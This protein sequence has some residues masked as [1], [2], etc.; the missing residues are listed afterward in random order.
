MIRWWEHSQKGVT[1]GRTDRR[2]D[3]RTENTIHRAAWSQL[4][5]SLYPGYPVSPGHL[6]PSHWPSKT[7]RS[8]ILM[9]KGFLPLIAVWINDKKNRS[10][11]NVPNKIKHIKGYLQEST[12][13]L[14]ETSWKISHCAIVLEYGWYWMFPSSIHS[15]VCI[16]SINDVAL[17]GPH[18]LSTA[19]AAQITAS[20]ASLE[21]NK[22]VMIQRCQKTNPT[23]ESSVADLLGPVLLAWINLDLSM[24]K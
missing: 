23:K 19:S 12:E 1:D 18:S 13:R 22:G 15:N 4:K 9:T 20:E 11:L 3:R 2:T 14:S 10:I 8:L 5:M 21:R 24:D 7:D 17:V 16:R 6:H